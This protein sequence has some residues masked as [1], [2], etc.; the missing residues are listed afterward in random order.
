MQIQNHIGKI[1]WTVANRSLY[2]AYFFVLLIQVNALKPSDYGLFELMR[3]LNIWMLGLSDSLILQGLIQFGMNDSQRNKV[4]TIALISYTTILMTVSLIIYS[5]RI[6][7]SNIFAEESIIY[8]AISLPILTMLSIPRNFIIKILY[9]DYLLK[10]VFFIDLIYFF[11][12]TI[13]T[14]NYIAIYNNLNFHLMLNIL[15][16]GTVL[17]SLTAIVLA[18]DKLKFGLSSDFR[19]SYLFGYGTPLML[20]GIFHSLPKYLDVFIVQ[21]FFNISTVGIYSLTKNLYRIFDDIT[22]TIYGLIFP[23][24]VK[25]FQTGNKDEI[26]SIM[27]KSVSFT[28]SIFILIITVLELG[29]SEYLIMTFLPERYYATITQFNIALIAAIFLPLL[30]LTAIITASGK[31]HITMAFSLIS[32]ICSIAGFIIIGYIKNPDYIPVGIILYNTIIGILAYIYVNKNYGFPIKMIFRSI[33]DT[34]EF[35]K[36][37]LK[38]K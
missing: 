24:T 25:Q 35:F 18:F 33:N 21:F 13:L 19:V 34:T 11:T 9:R 29:L 15:L 31:P 12:M 3:N 27:T 38:L 14:F 32:A 8:V 37:V 10:R 17:S 23:T 1:S 30:L 2:F 6:P 4:N 36:K 20:Q 28:F 26:I 7:L 22:S 5:L 16:W